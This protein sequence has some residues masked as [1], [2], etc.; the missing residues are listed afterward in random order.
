MPFRIDS[1]SI[2]FIFFVIGYKSKC[3]MDKL[4][5]YRFLVAVISLLVLVTCAYCNLNYDSINGNLSINACQWGN[6]FILF[7][8]SGI[9]GTLLLFLIC[10]CIKIKSSII[11]KISN[12]TIIILGFHHSLYL[13][14]RNRITSDNFYFAVF[15]SMFIL[16]L[17]YLLVILSA[18]FFPI[19]LGGRKI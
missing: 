7:V 9:A 16:F 11:M 1:S 17:C 2:G 19:L 18:K 3:F 15:F 12:G 6:S 14:F 8:L 5:N 13:F 10:Q 4:L